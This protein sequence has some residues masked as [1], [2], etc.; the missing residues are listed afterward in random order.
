[1]YNSENCNKERIS[2]EIVQESIGII[3]H[4]PDFLINKL[5]NCTGWGYNGKIP[6]KIF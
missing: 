3:V 4:P 6:D 5:Y 2:F 1:M